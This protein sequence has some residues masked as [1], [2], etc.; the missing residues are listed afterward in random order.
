M[1]TLISLKWDYFYF[2]IVLCMVSAIK[3]VCM[4]M[5]FAFC[6]ACFIG[7]MVQYRQTNSLIKN[8]PEAGKMLGIAQY[9]HEDEHAHIIS[10]PCRIDH[11]HYGGNVAPP[12]RHL[13]DDYHVSDALDCT[14]TLVT[15]YFA[16]PC[17]HGASEYSE[18]IQNL[19][20]NPLY[21]EWTNPA[22]AVGP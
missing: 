19:V 18:W 20:N 9:S 8:S 3:T 4:P 21:G 17:K 15:A 12:P 5:V 10:H 14:T 2:S 13:T 6:V 11:N 22:S 16:I 7:I 1:M